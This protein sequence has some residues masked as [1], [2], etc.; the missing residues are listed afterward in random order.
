MSPCLLKALGRIYA[1]TLLI[2]RSTDSR[3]PNARNVS[4]GAARGGPY[5]RASCT[6]PAHIAVQI[7]QFSLSFESEPRTVRTILFNAV[8]QDAETQAA[9]ERYD[10]QR[11]FR[12][13]HHLLDTLVFDRRL[14]RP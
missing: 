6:C 10:G 3:S 8:Q 5:A 12:G 14:R 7:L 9:F 13:V 11:G 1:E 2:G 4:T